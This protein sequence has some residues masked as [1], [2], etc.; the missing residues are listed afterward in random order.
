LLVELRRR[1]EA[2]GPDNAIEE[3]IA[4]ERERERESELDGDRRTLEMGERGEVQHWR[5]RRP[6][7]LSREKRAKCG[8]RYFLC[9]VDELEGQVACH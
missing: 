7:V 4:R 8:V 2:E 5:N 3:D 6:S 1:S 9:G